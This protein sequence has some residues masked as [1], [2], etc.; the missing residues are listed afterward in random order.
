MRLKKTHRSD[1]KT[2]SYEFTFYSDDTE[3]NDSKTITI[4]PGRDGVTDVEISWLHKADDREVYNNEKNSRSDFNDE[5]TEKRREWKKDFRKR[6]KERHG[7]YPNEDDTEYYCSQ[8]FSGSWA[9]SLDKAADDFCDKTPLIEAVASNSTSDS[10]ELHE[11]L[12][13]FGM[14][15]PEVKRSVFDKVILQGMKKKDAAVE[16][17]LSD[18]RISQISKELEKK[19]LSDKKLKEIFRR[20]SVSL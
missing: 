4:I 13:E 2:Y 6:F 8:A 12:H 19:L 15:L 3:N 16:L 9:L 10:N 18:V 11:Y 14:S 20:A 17:G 1:R 7:Y 5:G